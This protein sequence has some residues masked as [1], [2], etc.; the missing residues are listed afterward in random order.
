M[1][2]LE[3]IR[4]K[5]MRE[6]MKRLQTREEEQRKI[7][8]SQNIRKSVEEIMK[9]LLDDEAYEYLKSVEKVSPE[10]ADKIKIVVINAFR[11]GY[12]NHILTRPE[13]RIIER[14]IT[15]EE[16]KI[17]IKRRGEEMIDLSKAMREKLSEHD[18]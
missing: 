1:D 7:P 9:N 4:Q 8:K 18:E 5:K 17:F 11:F 13:I 2:E 3:A 16:G 6:L 10:I 15:G 14:K 12:I